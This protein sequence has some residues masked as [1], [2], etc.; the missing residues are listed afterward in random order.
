MVYCPVGAYCVSPVTC[1]GSAEGATE[2]FGDGCGSWVY[3]LC[4]AG[5]YNPNTH[6]PTEEQ[7]CL[8]C[9]PG[10][11]CQT[12]GLEYPTGDCDPG[13]F[14]VQQASSRSPTT[15]TIANGMRFGQCPAGH[16]CESGTAYPAPCPAGTYLTT[17]LAE[18]VSECVPCPA[19]SF[20]ED[21][22]ISEVTADMVC[23]PGFF[24]LSGSHTAAPMTMADSSCDSG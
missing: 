17:T 4:P 15:D 21:T 14:C 20:C 18:D 7:A 16:Y 1:E 5:T 6:Q 2:I 13:H 9:P 12:T 11:Y 22:G 8:M 19:G 3:E 24:C 10:K 23:Q